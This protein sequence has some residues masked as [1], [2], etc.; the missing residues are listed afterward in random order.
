M[1]ENNNEISLRSLLLERTHDTWERNKERND[2]ARA[3]IANPIKE[4]LEALCKVL[5]DVSDNS[6]LRSSIAGAFEKLAHPAT[7]D[8]LIQVARDRNDDSIVRTFA[9][10]S[11]RA[12]GDSRAIATLLDLLHDT[13]DN[14]ARSFAANIL[15]QMGNPSVIAD[16]IHALADPEISVRKSVVAT[17]GNLQ[18]ARAIQPLIQTL[19]SKDENSS[20]RARAALSL[21]DLRDF[22]GTKAATILRTMCENTAESTQVRGCAAIGWA[23]LKD[24]AALNPLLNML[25][26]SDPEL[27]RL[28]AIA[29]GWLADARAVDHLIQSLQDDNDA[30]VRS[31][32]VFALDKIGDSRAFESLLAALNDESPAVRWN[33]VEALSSFDDKRRVDVLVEALKQNEEHIRV[34]A[35]SALAEV[36]DTRAIETLKWAGD[37]YTAEYPDE[38]SFKEATENAIARIRERTE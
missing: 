12:F 30:G 23:R 19:A 13:E 16:L 20:V 3:L 35:I 25:S 28:T 32:A 29:L 11:L 24:E 4:N 22:G 6:S 8:A 31:G 38:Y 15:G 1:N 17:L 33:V 36:G 21:G 27:R 14:S 7:L 18:D 5:T 10:Q 26:D 37:N 34:A 2:A 9:V